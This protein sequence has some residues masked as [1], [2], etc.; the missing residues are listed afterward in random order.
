MPFWT[1]EDA[2]PY[3][4]NLHKDKMGQEANPTP[5]LFC[6]RLCPNFEGKSSAD[7]REAYKGTLSEDTAIA[8][9]NLNKNEE[10]P[11]LGGFS[12]L[13]F[14]KLDKRKGRSTE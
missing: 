8:K 7:E 1:V 11:T 9:G 12:T 13:L 6:F 2:G 3:K 5:F 10:N 14:F 4:E